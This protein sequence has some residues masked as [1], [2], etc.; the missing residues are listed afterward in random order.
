MAASGGTRLG[1]GGDVRAPGYRIECKYTERLAYTLK[2]SDL[3]KIRKHAHDSLEQP[4]LQL[5]F[6]D[7][8]GRRTEFAFIRAIS[9]TPDQTIIGKS[10]TISKADLSHKLLTKS[11]Y[12]IHFHNERDH[13]VARNWSD[14]VADALGDR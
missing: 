8:A 13:W 4:V 9:S 11:S 7:P 12:T 10:L 5:A 2:L 3:Q 6:V 14:F 1:G